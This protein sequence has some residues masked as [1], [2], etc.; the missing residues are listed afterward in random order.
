MIENVCMISGGDNNSS[1]WIKW[2]EKTEQSHRVCLP[3][4]YN[5]IDNLK[6]DNLQRQVTSD[7]LIRL[8][9]YLIEVDSNKWLCG[10][11][12]KVNERKG[13]HS[14]KFD[15]NTSMNSFVVKI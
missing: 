11:Y 5:Q 7:K 8:K 4:L 15:Q 14:L 13:L 2:I 6:R 10:F 12:W 1:K 9:W 3:L